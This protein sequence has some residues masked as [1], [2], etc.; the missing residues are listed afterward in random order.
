MK[1]RIG[2]KLTKFHSLLHI[3]FFI[4]EYGAPLN[5]FK[6]H[7]EEFLKHFV[8]KIYPRTTRQHCRYL[9]DLTVRLL[10]NQCLQ[11][12]EEDVKLRT[13]YSS[14]GIP[15]TLPTEPDTNSNKKEYFNEDN[16][17]YLCGSKFKIVK[18]E[19]YNHWHTHANHHQNNC[20]DEC[21]NV[22]LYYPWINNSFYNDLPKQ[23]TQEIDSDAEQDDSLKT[24]CIRIC[25]E[26]KISSNRHNNTAYD[27]QIGC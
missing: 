8:K 6:G 9:Y 12:W 13:M 19:I 7:L 15:T 10:E 26:C 25:S 14:T 2:L 23:L 18:S 20:T 5:F 16:Q 11:S 24:T 22:G 4:R 1:S 17:S 27:M 21:G 3:D